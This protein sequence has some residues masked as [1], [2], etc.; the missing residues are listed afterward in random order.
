MRTVLA[1][2]GALALSVP[3]TVFAQSGNDNGKR[4]SNGEVQKPVTTQDA[5][6][7]GTTNDSQGSTS[8][9]SSGASS[10]PK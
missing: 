10:S 1:I 7:A 9:G 8:G 2:V 3:A 6:S 5:G 4:N